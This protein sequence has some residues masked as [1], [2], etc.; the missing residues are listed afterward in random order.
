[1][2]IPMKLALFEGQV[3]TNLAFWPKPLRM[4]NSEYVRH[5]DK[6]ESGW[7]VFK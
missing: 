4:G 2:Y 1:M 3:L 7:I 6:F 5:F